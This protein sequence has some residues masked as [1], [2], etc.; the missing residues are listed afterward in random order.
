[1][2]NPKKRQDGRYCKTVTI[3]IKNGKYIRKNVYG[4]TLKEL[5]KNYRDFMTLYD[6]GV[7]LENQNI[8]TYELAE[9]WYDVRKARVLAAETKHRYATRFR[10]LKET[11]IAEMKVAEVK[12]FNIDQII[13]GFIDSGREATAE[14]MRVFLKDI[15]D[16]AIE[17]D[18]ILK[19]PCANI[20]VSYR[21]KEKRALTE[22]EKKKIEKAELSPR[23]KA[24]LY[25]FRYTGARRGEILALTKGD[26][27]LERG[28]IRINK[29][30][31][32]NNGHA[33]VEDKTKTPAG[34]RI[35]PIL[36]PL[37]EPL[38][39]YINILDG[40]ALFYNRAGK[41]MSNQSFYNYFR[42]IKNIVGLPDDVSAHIFR[43]SFISECYQAGVQ[44]K[45]LQQ[46]VGH[47]DIRTTLNT[48]THLEKEFV[49]DGDEM[50]EYYGYVV[51]MSSNHKIRNAANLE[52]AVK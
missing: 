44:V 51:K 2:S 5:D 39:E 29:T 24:F 14:V 30:V 34:D 38:K 19:N 31:V 40:D 35:M 25:I 47:A 26:I 21:A 45:K 15:F 49:Q 12:P 13:A 8:T 6:K 36:A 22:I 41:P 42:K 32:D 37:Y 3:G 46:W 7:V 28:C 43:H 11:K 50:N 23:D 18:L 4:K 27:D 17:Q 52:N 9:Q 10:H 48:Y 16:Y 20:I 33:F 1:V